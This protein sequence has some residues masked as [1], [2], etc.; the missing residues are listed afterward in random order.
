[1]PARSLPMLRAITS[2]TSRTHCPYCAFQCG[3]A[4]TTASPEAAR[5]DV[6]ADDEF[7]VNRG[8]MCVKGFTSAELVDHP[9]RLTVPLLR[10]RGGRLLAASWDTALDFIAERLLRLREVHG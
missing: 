4:I 6:K 5:L 2:V 7:P 9:D 3:M 1:M 10:G 8:Q